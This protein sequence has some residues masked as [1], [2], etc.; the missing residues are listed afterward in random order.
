MFVYVQYGNECGGRAMEFSSNHSIT[1][2][3]VI[4]KA[5]LRYGNCSSLQ[6]FNGHGGELNSL[7]K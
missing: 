3:N 2:N 7:K 1:V 4:E 5:R 6:L